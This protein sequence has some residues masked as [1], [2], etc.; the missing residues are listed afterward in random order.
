[1]K[2]SE[3]GRKIYVDQ[4]AHFRYSAGWATLHK[5]IE[6]EAPGKQ[7]IFLMLFFYFPGASP[8]VVLFVVAQPKYRKWAIY[9]TD[10]SKRM[11]ILCF[12]S[13]YVIHFVHYSIFFGSGT[14]LCLFFTDY[15]H[16]SFVCFFLLFFLPVFFL[17]LLFSFFLSLL[18]FFFFFVSLFLPNWQIWNRFLLVHDWPIKSVLITCTWN[19]HGG[20]LKLLKTLFSAVYLVKMATRLYL[21]FEKTPQWYTK[22]KL[23]FLFDKT[24]CKVVAD[25]EY[26]VRKKFDIKSVCNLYLDGFLLPSQENIEIV[27]DGDS[28]RYVFP[29]DRSKNLIASKWESECR[30]FHFFKVFFSLLIV[31]LMWFWKWPNN[32]KLYLSMKHR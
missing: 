29:A 15:V 17:F 21:S 12:G 19:C 23:L 32:L 7:W 6:D 5:T 18:S 30:F 3:R 10:G 2:P 26:L 28:L 1:M 24:A 14:V 9:K 31:L 8:S 4:I 11:K 27:R 25:L 13:F 22:K 20:R 16:L